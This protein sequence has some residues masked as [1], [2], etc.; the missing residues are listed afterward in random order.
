[1]ENS[2]PSV[3]PRSYAAR[4]AGQVMALG[5]G[6]M[7]SPRRWRTTPPHNAFG[8]VRVDSGV[9][10]CTTG[11]EESHCALM[12]RPP[13]PP[14]RSRRGTAR[15]SPR[16][17]PRSVSRTTPSARAGR[18]RRAHGASALRGW[19]DARRARGQAESRPHRPR[20]QVAQAAIPVATR[21]GQYPGAVAHRIGAGRYGARGRAAP[22]MPCRPLPRQPRRRHAGEGRARGHGAGRT[23]G[24]GGGG[25]SPAI[26]RQE[27]G[28]NAGNG[29]TPAAARSAAM[30][31]RVQPLRWQH[32][33]R[34][35]WRAFAPGGA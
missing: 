31:P 12:P 30:A 17:G 14:A 21:R 33:A 20:R 6:V 11:G 3:S 32:A 1:M 28:W 19:P 22:A 5:R 13:V 10:R 34:E 8:R 16:P 15:T 4:H 27:I 29:R 26:A 25:V 18:T 35:S 9:A 7:V 2:Q 24:E 23:G